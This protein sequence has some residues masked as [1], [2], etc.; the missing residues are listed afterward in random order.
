[1]QPPRPA[2]TRAKSR[3]DHFNVEDTIVFMGS[4][5]IRSREAAEKM[6][7]EGRAGDG[8]AETAL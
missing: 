7:R 2:N 4:A 6:V 5:R 1:V 3:F 8:G